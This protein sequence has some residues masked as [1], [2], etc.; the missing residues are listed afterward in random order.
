MN[1]S[2]R[3]FIE[4]LERDMRPR[5]QGEKEV[6]LNLKS[7]HLQHIELRRSSLSSSLKGPEPEGG[8]L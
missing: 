7:G 3:M 1:P 6:S 2:M 5:D 8:D 4:H